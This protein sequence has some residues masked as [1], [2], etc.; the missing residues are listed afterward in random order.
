MKIP[1]REWVCGRHWSHRP[2]VQARTL[3]RSLYSPRICTSL[4]KLTKWIFLFV[5]AWAFPFHYYHRESDVLL[6]C[7][8]ST[9]RSCKESIKCVIISLFVFPTVLSFTKTEVVFVLIVSISP[10]LSTC[11]MLNKNICWMN[12]WRNEWW[13]EPQWAFSGLTMPQLHW[14]KFH[15]RAL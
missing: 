3:V 14:L 4:L 2:M 11:Q 7:T 12:K 5:R 15:F 10:E 9:C 8:Y 1:G 13:Y 6:F